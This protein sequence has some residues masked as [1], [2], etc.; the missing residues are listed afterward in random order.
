MPYEAVGINFRVLLFSED[1]YYSTTMRL[2]SV[3]D[4]LQVSV[5]V[6]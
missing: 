5:V 4:K 2:C 1:V 6:Y 3:L